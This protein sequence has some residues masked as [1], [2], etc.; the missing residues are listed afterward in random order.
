MA[1]RLCRVTTEIDA[2]AM[3][4]IGVS[5]AF[6]SSPGRLRRDA[7]DEGMRKRRPRFEFHA[8][9]AGGTAVTEQEAVRARLVAFDQVRD[10]VV[11]DRTGEDQATGVVAGGDVQLKTGFGLEV[12]VAFDESAAYGSPVEAIESIGSLKPRETCP[13]SVNDAAGM[14]VAEAE[15]AMAECTTSRLPK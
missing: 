3:S 10:A 6:V 14:T 9:D 2:G 1:R 11:I 7:D 4:S 15:P 13:V 5:S 12:R 8:L